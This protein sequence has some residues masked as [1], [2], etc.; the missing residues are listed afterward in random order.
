MSFAI[1]EFITD[2]TC[3]VVQQSWLDETKKKCRFPPNKHFSKSIQKVINPEKVATWKIYDVNII[4]ENINEYEEANELAKYTSEFGDTEGELTVKI[5]KE[6][7]RKRAIFGET[8]D[9]RAEMKKAK[10]DVA[11]SSNFS[12]QQ[13]IDDDTIIND[14]KQSDDFLIESFP[15][16]GIE[17]EFIP[18]PIERLEI[19]QD[20]FIIM[21]VRKLINE[22]KVEIFQKIDEVLDEVRIINMR[23]GHSPLKKFEKI[24]STKAFNS[25]IEV[26]KVEQ[27]KIKM[28]QE[29]KCLQDTTNSKNTKH[30]K[31]ATLIEY[32]F[33]PKFII[34]RLKWGEM[35]GQQPS[36]RTF[37]LVNYP[38]FI[39]FGRALLETATPKEI[40]TS[41]QVYF[42]HR[43][44]KLAV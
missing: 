26:M 12:Q 35:N 24:K 32:M 15:Y 6:N 8:L 44:K 2:N 41:F 38:I 1:V 28:I 14:L 33:T 17:N 10:G 39:E 18:N 21:E 31:I 42:K 22:A 29:L 9:L 11:N 30:G 27:K 20:S 16:D 40:R 37:Y 19:D 23:L 43:A 34:K 3:S 25:F 36:D 7:K 4:H 5:E 13:N